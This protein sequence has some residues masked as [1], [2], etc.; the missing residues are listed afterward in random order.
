MDA[1]TEKMEMLH[2]LMKMD[3]ESKKKI[4][5]KEDRFVVLHLQYYHFSISNN[6]H[7]L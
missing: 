3:E 2:N 1:T 7:I 4:L 6:I 5:S